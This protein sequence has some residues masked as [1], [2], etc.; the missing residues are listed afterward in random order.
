MFRCTFPT[1][2]NR[3]STHTLKYNFFFRLRRR[4]HSCV[5][6]CVR[7]CLS[8][9]Y[10]RID[11]AVALNVSTH[12]H[13][14]LVLSRRTA[15]L[16]SVRVFCV[17]ASARCRQRQLPSGYSRSM[18]ACVSACVPPACVR[19]RVRVSSVYI[20]LCVC[21]LF[22]EESPRY[23]ECTASHRKYGSDLHDV[24]RL[25]GN[26]GAGHAAKFEPADCVCVRACGRACARRRQWRACLRAIC[27][28]VSR[29]NGR[30]DRSSRERIVRVRA[31]THT[32][33][34]L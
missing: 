22:C 33:T 13:T 20:L 32:H 14:Q 25:P 18:S 6:A 30:G 11:I 28:P 2:L 5:R 34:H 4:R 16:S 21:I 9:L 27:E 12:A 31:S 10:R 8:R 24:I 17:C 7:A 15:R 29:D 26:R 23:S 3:G 19:V 1:M